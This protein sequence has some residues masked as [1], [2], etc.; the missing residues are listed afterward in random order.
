MFLL[1]SAQ[2]AADPEGTAKQVLT[3]LENAG[4]Q[5]DAH[6]PWQDGRLAYEIDG[7]KKGLHYLVLFRLDGSAMAGV[8][9]QCRLSDAII[10]QLMLKHPRVLY[11][12]IIETL[13]GHEIQGNDQEESAPAS[14]DL[15]GDIEE[16][17][18]EEAEVAS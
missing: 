9:R 5:I 3:I 16:D 18:E 8:T 4:A 15:E 11:D 6:R 12:A 17:I 2:F 14:E 7:H 13:S 10:R 1:D